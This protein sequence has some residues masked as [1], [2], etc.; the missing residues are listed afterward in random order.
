MKESLSVV[1]IAHNEEQNIGTM[2]EGLLGNYQKEIL[3]LIVVDDCSTDKTPLI[4]ES[5][6]RR[7]PKVKLVKRNPPPGVGR[8]LKIGF[9]NVNSKADYVLTMDSDFTQNIKD[10]RLLIN[11]IEENIYD[12]VIGSRFVKGGRLINYPLLK[13]IMNR[14]FHI[15]VKMIFPVKQKDLTNNFKLYKVA[16]VKNLP[17]RSD[18]YAMNAETG[19]LPILAGYRIKEVPIAWVGRSSRMGKSKFRITRVGGSYIKVIAYCL[20]VF[21]KKK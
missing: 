8:A 12:G 17:W 20:T 19:I 13:K 2:I 7:N 5:W 1:L 4:V 10:V 11:A 16:I 9:A 3:E 14:I 6:S 18:N 15:V 21:A